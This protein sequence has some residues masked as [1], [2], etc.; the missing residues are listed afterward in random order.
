MLDPSK[1]VEILRLHFSEG[2]GCRQIAKQLGINR[3][4]V[5]RVIRRRSVATTPRP[6]QNRPSILQPF[7]PRIDKLLED[8]RVLSASVHEKG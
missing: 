6:P 5:K 4:S 7:Y 8:A 3:K 2:L 1:Q